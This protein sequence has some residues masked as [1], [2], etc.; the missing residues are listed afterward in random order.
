MNTSAQKIRLKSG[1]LFIPLLSWAYLLLGYLCWERWSVLV[2][3][4]ST[5]KPGREMEH[6]KCIW[7]K[8]ARGDREKS[9]KVR[10]RATR[11]DHSHGE[12][13]TYSAILFNDVL[14]HAV[15][16]WQQRLIGRQYSE[17]WKAEGAKEQYHG[18]LRSSSSSSLALFSSTSLFSTR[19]INFLSGK[20]SFQSAN[21]MGKVDINK[22]W[23]F[24]M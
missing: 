23:R 24:S 16:Y 13:W 14:C 1:W 17:N 2:W 3:V 9:P 15:C 11:E 5:C 7:R 22:R 19:Y 21:F 4:C 10:K 18:F 8:T 20:S 12:N 6:Y